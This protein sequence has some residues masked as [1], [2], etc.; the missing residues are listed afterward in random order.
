MDLVTKQQMDTHLQGQALVAKTTALQ[1]GMIATKAKVG[2][3]I[4]ISGSM[5]NEFASGTVQEQLERMFAI[6]KHF[7]DDGELD[8][9]VFGTSAKFVGTVNNSNWYDAVRYEH[10]T[11][12]I[13]GERFR[14]QGGTKY[15]TALEAA[16]SYYFGSTW[17]N[18]SK[19]FFGSTKRPTAVKQDYP[20]FLIFSTDGD[21]Q[22]QRDTLKLIDKGSQL[23][24]FVQFAAFGR[25]PF[26]GLQ[27]IDDLQGRYVDNAGMFETKDF[28]SVA[29]KDLYAALLNEFPDWLKATSS[30]GWY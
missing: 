22:D 12:I 16:Y 5:A 21:N 27:Q 23:P 14:L 25:G 2:F 24:L 3:V 11:A 18:G 4:D 30:E 17:D 8:I 19:S 6:A 9:F 15:A 13:L 10:G 1:R 7:D 28:R 26:R 29:D 20:V